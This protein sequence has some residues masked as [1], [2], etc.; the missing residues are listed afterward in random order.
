LKQLSLNTIKRSFFR[1][2]K[3]ESS[4]IAFMGVAL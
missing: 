2:C 4:K 3:Y 1:K